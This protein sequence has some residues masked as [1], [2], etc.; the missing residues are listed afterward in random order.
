MTNSRIRILLV[1]V[2]LYSFVSCANEKRE[3]E[4]Y[5]EGMKKMV[6]TNY[7]N[8]N[9]TCVEKFFPNG[10]LEDEFCLIDESI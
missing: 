1:C 5:P 6:V 8:E 2:L 7:A 4:Y 9:R 3:I 10:R